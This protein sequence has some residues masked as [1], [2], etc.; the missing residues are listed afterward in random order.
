MWTPS[1]HERS[2]P[3]MNAFWM[4][5]GSTLSERHRRWALSG[6]SGLRFVDIGIAEVRVREVGPP[7]APAFVFAVDSPIGIEHHDQL[8]ASWPSDRRAVVME[9]P[10]LGFSRARKG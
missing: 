7:G 10:G 9:M 8:L 5:T 2:S 6:R 1:R 4:D 3:G